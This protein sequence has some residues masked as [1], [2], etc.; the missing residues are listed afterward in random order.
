MKFQGLCQGNWAAPAGWALISI[1]ILNA[2]DKKG[3]GGKFVCPVSQRMGHLAAILFVDDNNL[4][5]IDMDQDQTAAE[6]HEDL[7]ASVNSWCKLLIAS[8]GSLKPEK[9]FL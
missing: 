9:C 3:R 7:Q 6:A 8:G 1:T 2:H 4:I 5:R